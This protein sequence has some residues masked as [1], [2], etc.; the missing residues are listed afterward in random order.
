M[1][2]QS[3]VQQL[4]LEQGAYSPLD[5]L[6]ATGLLAQADYL[7]WRRGEIGSL[8]ERLSPTRVRRRAP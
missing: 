6:L 4:L 5:L 7:A 3:A 2:A 8:N 1:D